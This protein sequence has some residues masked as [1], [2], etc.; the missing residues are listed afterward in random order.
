MDESERISSALAQ[1]DRLVSKDALLRSQYEPWSQPSFCK[2]LFSFQPANWTPRDGSCEATA[3]ALHGWQSAG[4]PDRLTCS[5][6]KQTLYQP[7]IT[8]L[9]PDFLQELALQYAGELGERHAANC[10]WISGS[11][12]RRLLSYQPNVPRI[13]MALIEGRRR[14]LA[15]HLQEAQ[16]SG[17]PHAD[18]LLACH[19]WDH[20]PARGIH[21]FLGCSEHVPLD[22][23][24]D[25]A[26]EHRWLCPM[27]Y[28]ESRE[29]EGAG[30]RVLRDIYSKFKK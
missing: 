1:V 30:H 27:V 19:G 24:F 3:A 15:A 22:S 2:R 9:C 25:A 16:T 6:C 7:W 28:I 21:C 8:E 11:S 13:E 23:S 29:P 17:P 5:I 20:S 26:A 18:E 10:P 12:P 14:R 4:H